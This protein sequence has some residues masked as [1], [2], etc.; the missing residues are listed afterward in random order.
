MGQR[1][2]G[3]GGQGRVGGRGKA[4]V[5]VSFKAKSRPP[6]IVWEV[7]VAPLEERWAMTLRRTDSSVGLRERSLWPSLMRVWLSS[8][9]FFCMP[10]MMLGWLLGDTS[11]H[12]LSYLAT[13]MERYVF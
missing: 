2:G 5:W 6:E 10:V 8:S 12:L 3:A 7:L 1:R 13:N 9:I 4:I 11:G